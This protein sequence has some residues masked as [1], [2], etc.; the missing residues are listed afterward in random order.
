MKLV[1]PYRQPPIAT[2]Q[3]TIPWKFR[4]ACFF[5]NHFWIDLTD[6]SKHD[7]CFLC[8]RDN[9]LNGRYHLEN[10]GVCHKECKYCKKTFDTRCKKCRLS[11]LN[12]PDETIVSQ[13]ISIDP[14]VTRDIIYINCSGKNK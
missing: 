5:N 11:L 2:K 3:K 9:L 7:F 6:Y 14:L 1:T 12:S 10:N 13:I 4:V 8:Q